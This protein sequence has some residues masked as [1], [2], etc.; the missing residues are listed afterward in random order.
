VRNDNLFE[1]RTGEHVPTK[2]HCFAANDFTCPQGR[3]RQPNTANVLTCNLKQT[4]FLCVWQAIHL[5][6]APPG[7]P[8]YKQLLRR[9]GWSI[10]AIIAPELVAL[11]AWLQHR[12]A[13]MLM[14]DVNRARGL[15]QV[16]PGTFYQRS[17]DCV[18]TYA[19]KAVF[20]LLGVPA[21]L[22]MLFRHRKEMLAT[23]REQQ[24]TD[25]N[26]LHTQLDNDSLPWTIDIAFYA[27]SGAVIPKD[28]RGMNLAIG[29]GDIKHLALHDRMALIS[30]QRAGLQDS[31]KASGL[32]KI[33]TCTQAL[34]FC[35]QCIARLSQNMA[36]SLIELNTFAHCISAFFIYAFWWHKPYDVEAHVSFD[37]PE[38]LQNY[39]LS[40]IRQGTRQIVPIGERWAAQEFTILERTP[41]G[42]VSTVAD[43]IDFDMYFESGEHMTHR[44]KHGAKIP[45]TELTLV[46]SREAPGNCP[47]LALSDH[48]LALW[49]RLWRLRR[50]T[51]LK[52]QLASPYSDT[53]RRAKNVDA[54]L[55]KSATGGMGMKVPLIL[56]STCLAYGGVHLLA[57]QY[58]FQT[59]AEGIMWR[60]ASTITASSGLIVL[61]VQTV[62][63]LWNLTDLLLMRLVHFFFWILMAPAYFILAAEILGRSFLIIESFRALPNSPSSVYEIP[64]WTAYLPHF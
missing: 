7:E 34:W 60:I 12:R 53:C 11:N 55:E 64:R 30:I 51:R 49:E 37:A 36:I 19:G 47:D 38:L 14:K 29:E 57:W 1:K 44:I 50:N 23:Q 27:I 32:A 56:T 59:N 61:Y 18:G 41:D 46:R 40:Q 43:S 35:S 39:L 24:Q 15:T 16:S 33:I 20:A 8:Q 54:D 17:W 2:S 52:T 31:G 9:V 25:I 42:Q 4:I 5:N 6:V 3:S 22:R 28:D 21:S 48:V 13:D 58:N 45:M 10:L 62:S 63:Y 26:R